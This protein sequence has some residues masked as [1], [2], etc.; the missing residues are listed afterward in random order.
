MGISKNLK[1]SKSDHA[2]LDFLTA[3]FAKS[4]LLEM[5]II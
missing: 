2:I 3:K 5:P 4:R 1:L